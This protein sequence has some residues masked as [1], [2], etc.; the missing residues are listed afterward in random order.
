RSGETL[1]EETKPIIDDQREVVSSNSWVMVDK[2]KEKGRSGDFDESIISLV[3][4][5]E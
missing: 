3:E 5:L 2:T 1:L 4:A